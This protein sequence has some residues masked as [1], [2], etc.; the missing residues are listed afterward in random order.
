MRRRSIRAWPFVE[1]DSLA[2]DGVFQA[3]NP[4][5]PWQEVELRLIQ[6]EDHRGNRGVGVVRQ[7]TIDVIAGVTTMRELALSAIRAGTTLERHIHA[8]GISGSRC[9]RTLLDEKRVLP[10]LDHEDP[11]HCMV[12][13]TGPTH[14]GSASVR[15]GMHRNPGLGRIGASDPLQM[16]NL[17]IAG[18]RAMKG[19]PGVQPAWFYKGDGAIVVRPGAAFPLPDFAEGAGEEPELA[20]LYV[21]G[22]DGTP[23]RLGFAIG[24]EFSDHATERKNYLYLGHSK[25]RYCSF[26]PELHTGAMPPS[27]LGMSRIRRDGRVIWEK[28]FLTGQDNMCHSVEN[29]EYHHFKYNQFLRPGNVHVHFLGAALLS[30]A[31]AVRTEPGDVFEITVAGFGEP[32]I[33]GTAT[34]RPRV[35]VSGVAAL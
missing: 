12:S 29:L 2:I 15:D 17:G 33:N 28:E 30:F 1:S 20:G 32:L 7:E 24:N 35:A 31:D 6:F 26:G 13:G 34:V 18:G 11:G 21:V 3:V 14:P 23:Y 4:S 5:H 10:P 27:L 9:Y 22:D 19:E 16:F 8:Q 25:L